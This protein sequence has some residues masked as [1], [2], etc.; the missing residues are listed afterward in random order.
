MATPVTVA[1]HFSLGYFFLLTCPSRWL[2]PSFFPLPHLSPNVLYVRTTKRALFLI[3]DPPTASDLQE[4]RGARF[5]DSLDHSRSRIPDRRRS[6]CL[7]RSPEGDPRS[8]TR[9][10][11]IRRE[12]Y[13]CAKKSRETGYYVALIAT[14]RIHN[15]SLCS[16]TDFFKSIRIMKSISLLKNYKLIYN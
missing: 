16:F 3:T 7:S 6:F 14:P 8:F 4:S 9:F 1:C 10:P 13:S 15:F 12:V 11:F 5:R 2:P